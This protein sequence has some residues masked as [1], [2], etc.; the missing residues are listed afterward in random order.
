MKWI[1]V[2]AGCALL[3]G[4]NTTPY[5]NG[6]PIRGAD[7]SANRHAGSR[8]DFCRNYARQ[9][10][11]NDY[12]NRVDRGEDGFGERAIHRNQALRQG[13]RAYQRCIEGRRG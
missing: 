6:T 2:A 4:C 8:D 7:L 1:V 3:A 5:P 11:A 9:T 13:D 12:E 10:A